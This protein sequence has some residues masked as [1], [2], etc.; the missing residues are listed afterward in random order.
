MIP[1]RL[2]TYSVRQLE[3]KALEFLGEEVS[4]PPV[5]IEH[6]LESREVADLDVWPKLRANHGILGA[7][8]LDLKSN[9]LTVFIDDDLADRYV[10]RNIYRITV[11]EELAHILL[12]REVIEAVRSV[13]DF[14]ELH[15]H[16][17]WHGID[18]EAKRLGAALL[19]PAPAIEE[20]AEIF[21]GRMV[22]QVGYQN[23]A[24]IKKQLPPVLADRFQVSPNAMNRRLK[25][26]PMKIYDKVDAVIAA[27]RLSRGAL[28]PTLCQPTG[29]RRRIS[30]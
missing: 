24:A 14:R 21:Y 28:R 20:Y 30:A 25:E 3:A 26:W 1:E 8:C 18:S 23:P 11:A 16:P 27:R 4:E 19:M 7:V 29:R 2:P 9:R 13:H 5:D 22:R 12:H 17:Q 10:H 15:R 6:L